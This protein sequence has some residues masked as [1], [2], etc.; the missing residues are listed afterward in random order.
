M[1]E[2]GFGSP[3]Q[4][5]GVDPD[6]NSY[7]WGFGSKTPSTWASTEYDTGFGSPRIE[8]ISAAVQLVLESGVPWLPDDGG[9]MV[10]LL[11]VWPTLGPFRVRLH[12]QS[13]VVYPIE[14]GFCHSG[15]LGPGSSL[16]VVDTAAPDTL[17][18]VLPPVPVGLYDVEVQWGLSFG[19]TSTIEDLID[20]VFRNRSVPTYRIR[21]RYSPEYLTGPVTA[22][23]DEAP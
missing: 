20:V 1:G 16:F 14:G 15:K 7:D 2:R 17:Q 6:P 5:G 19:D 10:T 13:G 9:V 12:G 4:I 3:T 11:A 8:L 22:R 21:H 18:F 23:S